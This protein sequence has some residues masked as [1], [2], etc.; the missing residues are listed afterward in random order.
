V[1]AGTIKDG[2]LVG[3]LRGTSRGNHARVLGNLSSDFSGGASNFQNGKFGSGS[4]TA[5][6][7]VVAG[8]P[9]KGARS[10]DEKEKSRHEPSRDRDEKG[11]G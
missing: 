1:F 5:V 4:S 11:K 8:R 2:K 3:Y 10:E 7:A 6:L 9:C